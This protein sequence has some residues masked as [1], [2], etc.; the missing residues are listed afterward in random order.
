MRFLHNRLDGLPFEPP[1]NDEPLVL[2]VLEH[3]LTS[4]GVP[5]RCR[6]SAV[7]N[8]SATAPWWRGLCC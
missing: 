1:G 2:Q 8:A 5:E 4:V 6:G 7:C 3:L